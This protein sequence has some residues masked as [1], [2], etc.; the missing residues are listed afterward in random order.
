M[1]GDPQVP[2]DQRQELHAGLLRAVDEQGVV[3]ASATAAC[4]V[5]QAGTVVENSLDEFV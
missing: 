4:K 5:D 1:H 2:G 3:V